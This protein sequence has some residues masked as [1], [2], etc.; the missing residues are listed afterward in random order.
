MRKVL[1][2]ILLLMSQLVGVQTSSAAGCIALSAPTVA[3]DGMTVTMISIKVVEKPGSNQ[4][5]ISYSL[6]NATPG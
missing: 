6:L 2:T 1:L 3:D 5:T 4:V